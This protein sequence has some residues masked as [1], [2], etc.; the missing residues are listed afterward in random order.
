MA[1]TL[2]EALDASHALSEQIIEGKVDAGDDAV[3]K[4]WQSL[5][6]DIAVA[7]EQEKTRQDVKQAEN[8][9]EAIMSSG[10]KEFAKGD[11]HTSAAILRHNVE[12]CR[13]N[14][15]DWSF[16]FGSDFEHH[17]PD[18]Q[19]YR[20]ST[21]V[22]KASSG[23]GFDL[24]TVRHVPTGI[25][26]EH[27]EGLEKLLNGVVTLE[28]DRGDTG[29]PAL[30]RFEGR[31]RQEMSYA[32][33]WT[34]MDGP[35]DYVVTPALSEVKT[36]R[37][38]SEGPDVVV[39]TK[40]N[41]VSDLADSSP[42]MTQDTTI[43][44][45]YASGINISKESFLDVFVDNW[46]KTVIYPRIRHTARSVNDDL[47]T[48]NGTDK[49]LGYWNQILASGH[50]GNNSRVTLTKSSSLTSFGITPEDIIDMR[51]SLNVGYQSMPNCAWVMNQLI[52]A[53]IAAIRSANVPIMTG[54]EG[55]VRWGSAEDASR[56]IVGYIYDKPV[57]ADPY[58][59]TAHATAN[60]NL[61]TFGTHE[62]LSVHMTAPRVF[63]SDH[64]S[65]GKHAV[66]CAITMVAAMQYTAS[67]ATSATTKGEILMG[68]TGT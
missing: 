11:N 28:T 12:Q 13:K 6:D 29:H 24:C 38:T 35:A 4:Q 9:Y 47:S 66:F 58:A 20:E 41:E 26:G 44:Y 63:V 25:K 50:G 56:G 61:L 33:L 67:V 36:N 43:P 62:N 46:L 1:T 16:G 34:N 65:A 53:K 23:N 2:Q 39:R 19:P 32:G 15:K 17:V 21:R 31:T 7:R 52:F 45:L 14:Y 3:A 40:A 10:A 57:F 48:G 59:S 37:I 51:G 64:T 27:G 55:I 60:T 22:V 8:A 42:S 68:Q 30:T 54:G 49:P 5:Q 18:G